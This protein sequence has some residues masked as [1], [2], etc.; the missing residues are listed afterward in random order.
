MVFLLTD[1]AKL[2]L[3]VE[4]AKILGYSAS[5]CDERTDTKGNED[6]FKMR[7]KLS[8]SEQPLGYKRTAVWV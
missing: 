5:I 7:F 3:I 1:A 4:C 2:R 6:C 8:V